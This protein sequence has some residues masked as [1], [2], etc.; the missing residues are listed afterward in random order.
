[1]QVFSRVNESRVNQVELTKNTIFGARIV[2]P[3]H[4]S[5]CGILSLGWCETKRE[6]YSL[7]DEATMNTQTLRKYHRLCRKIWV[8]GRGGV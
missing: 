6:L 3:K 2:F 4:L 8:G 7:G 5:S 1:M